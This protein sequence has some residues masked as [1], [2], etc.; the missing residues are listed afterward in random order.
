MVVAKAVRRAFVLAVP[1]LALACAAGSTVG[2]AQTAGA[3]KS[4]FGIFAEEWPKA[5]LNALVALWGSLLLWGVGH[6]LAARWEL[7]KKRVEEELALSRDF[8]AVAADFKMVAREWTRLQ[9]G[10]DAGRN[11]AKSEMMAL[12]QEELFKRALEIEARC[13]AMLLRIVS[14]PSF[15]ATGRLFS[16]RAGTISDEQVH[17]L[18][19]FR[20]A[21]RLLRERIEEGAAPPG[22]SD[23]DVWL[24]NRLAADISAYIDDRAGQVPQP[25]LATAG[26]PRHTSRHLNALYLELVSAREM[27]FSL[28]ARS[29][30]PLIERYE[31]SRRRDRR[32]HRVIN[33]R[34]VFDPSKIEIVAAPRTPIGPVATTSGKPSLRIEFAEDLKGFADQP[35]ATQLAA[36]ADVAARAFA[37]APGLAHHMLILDGPARIIVA[38]RHGAPLVLFGPSI[39]RTKE[40][41]LPIGLPF[42]TAT[43]VYAL[44]ILG[45][46]RSNRTMDEL[47]V[48]SLADLREAPLPLARQ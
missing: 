42:A 21:F 5:L 46:T 24:F 26:A 19:L 20:L 38:A 39:A 12:R 28:A 27:D 23:A 48:I 36:A 8:H 13:E 2:L 7:Y 18:S 47:R 16:S 22:Y 11:R 6:R 45:W 14:R 30:A 1:I 4:T 29:L 40:N 43:S 17:R 15:D 34:K 31:T 10:S 41:E 3:P 37:S 33:L 25:A 9:K 32:A 44:D 35:P